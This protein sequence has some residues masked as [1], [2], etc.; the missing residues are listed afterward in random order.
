MRGGAAAPYLW[1]LEGPKPRP[2]AQAEGLLSAASTGPAAMH[3]GYGYDPI[4]VLRA[5]RYSMAFL[6]DWGHIRMRTGASDAE[7]LAGWPCSTWCSRGRGHTA[8]SFQAGGV[9]FA[10]PALLLLLCAAAGPTA[11]AATQQPAAPPGYGR[12]EGHHGAQHCRTPV[13]V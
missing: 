9:R 4:R 12:R 13:Q 11:V 7:L 1:Q 6:R 5:V 2:Q 8:G 10:A 3:D